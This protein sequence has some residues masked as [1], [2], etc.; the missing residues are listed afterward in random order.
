M[1]L[2]SVNEVK[3]IAFGLKTSSHDSEGFDIWKF[4]AAAVLQPPQRFF[5]TPISPETLHEYALITGI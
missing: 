1:V 4:L 2:A 5:K 3:K